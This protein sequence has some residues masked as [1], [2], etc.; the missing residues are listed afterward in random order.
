MHGTSRAQP[1]LVMSMRDKTSDEKVATLNPA[2][3]RSRAQLKVN[4]MP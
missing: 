3:A 1:N 2:L 4:R